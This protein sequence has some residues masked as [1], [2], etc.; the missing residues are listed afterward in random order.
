M[1]I[2]KLFTQNNLQNIIIKIIINN[3]IGLL[4]AIIQ[5]N[6]CNL[7]TLNI[8]KEYQNKGYGSILLNYLIKYCKE[9]N[10]NYITV[11]DMSDNF[12]KKNNI[13]VKF[14]F[15]YIVKGFPEMI[16]SI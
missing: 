15:T 7:N 9:N 6:I 14:G 12:N 11:D 1:I 5:E 16:L 10:I 8:E 3:N 13:Y 4:H 2:T